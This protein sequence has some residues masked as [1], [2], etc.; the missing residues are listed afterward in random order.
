MI[1]KKVKHIEIILS[2]I[3]LAAVGV[4]AVLY[5]FNIYQWSFAPFFGH[6]V[7]KCSGWAIVGR[8]YEDGYSA[9]FRLG[10]R[11]QEVNG[12]PVE[13]MAGI[14]DL[15]N[16]QIGA[17]NR[18]VVSRNGQVHT[19][20]Y[21]TTQFGLAR[22]ALVFGVPW[23]MGILLIVIG[24]FVFLSTPIAD[25]RWSF[26]L[27]CLCAGLVMIFFNQRP[28]R[29]SWILI[30][31]TIGFCFLPATILHMTFI[32]PFYEEHAR[33]HLWYTTI[34]YAASLLLFVTTRSLSSSFTESPRYMR[35]FWLIY[36]FFSI[37]VF[38]CVLIYKYRKIPYRLA[39][40]KIRVILL[41]FFIGVLLPLV[42]PILNTLFGVFIF[43][44]IELAML[45]FITVFPLSIAYAIVKHDL[46]EIDVFVKRTTGYLLATT[47]IAFLYLLFILS[48]NVIVKPVFIQHHH[49]FNF[50][51]L[52]LVVFFFNPITSRAQVFVN[53]LFFR[54]KYDYKEPVKQLLKDI[55][56][57]FEPDLLILR[58]LNILSNT[59]FIEDIRI[60]LFDGEDGTYREYN[61][62]D[63]VLI[64]SNNAVFRASNPLV[65]V[66]LREK[67][68]VQKDNYCDQTRHFPYKKEMLRIFDSWNMQ[69]IIPFITHDKL[70]GFMMLGNMKSGRYYTIADVEFLRIIADQTAIALENV[71]LIHDRIEQE[72]IEEDLK[73]AGVIQRRMLPEGSPTIKDFVVYNQIIPSSEIGGDF[74]DFFEFPS[75]GEKELGIVMGDISG[76]GI[77]G[78]LL[79]SA[80]H[81][82][83]QNQVICIKDVAT[84][85]QE[86][87]RHMLRETKKKA[88]VAFIY[89]LLLPDKR[90]ILSN[91]GLPPPLYYDHDRK[92]TRFLKTEGE[93]LPL[94][95]FEE[96]SYTPLTLSL[97]K[98]DVILLYTDG[99]LE[100]KNRDNEFFNFH[101]LREIFAHS[102]HLDP[103]EIYNRIVEEL[104][105]FSGKRC[106]D[107]DMT[108]IILKHI[109]ASPVDT[110][111]FLPFSP[112]TLKIVSQGIE[113]MAHLYSLCDEEIVSMKNH[114]KRMY[115][116]A[117]QCHQESPHGYKLV[118]SFFPDG[119][120]RGIIKDG[121]AG[122]PDGGGRGDAS[123]GMKLLGDY[124]CLELAPEQTGLS[125]TSI[126][127]TSRM[128]VHFRG[129][130]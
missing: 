127:G 110:L 16:R 112:M 109:E 39:K 80:A 71:N 58:V 27:F 35:I 53:R 88:F 1:Q 6:G 102:V 11:I 37:L 104:R 107:D 25:R 61:P 120:N 94:G 77:S 51:F 126:R 12:M 54:Q 42:E 68:E 66:L 41:G 130:A 64:K 76:H 10:D 83:C 34:T 90:I 56:S 103:E 119:L 129:E 70:S 106:F 115:R 123:K 114:L 44:S 74:Y 20:I 45:P 89:A 124:H 75:Q 84:V 128:I 93:R 36:I 105:D 86:V 97:N 7:R 101:R 8:V 62:H 19:I 87:N 99:L 69:L 22:A 63:N 65:K 32:F 50:L 26:L 43:P 38:I 79:M 98:G 2:V 31:E 23:L 49:V 29:P 9:G 81:S 85:M 46:F 57:I 91:A 122:T 47:L 48:V 113:S 55:T 3:F 17:E 125:Q 14:R 78:A 72:K 121:H 33:R 116:K 95:I 67:R 100:V 24:S 111:L 60:F 28:L 18:F 15:V 40:S 82:I 52:L 118:A 21:R 108:I 92:E 5:L 117:A 73:I 4:V 13:S 96:L 59:M 30:F